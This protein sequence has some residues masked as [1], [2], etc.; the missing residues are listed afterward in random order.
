LSDK[1]GAQELPSEEEMVSEEEEI[2]VGLPFSDYVK[3]QRR[4]T[5]L[6][7][8]LEKEYKKREKVINRIMEYGTGIESENALRMYPTAVL[9]KWE[10]ALETFRAEK[11]KKKK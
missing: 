1:S 7:S 6:M 10:A 11:L 9:E 3:D 4:L 2:E 8:Q 5:Q